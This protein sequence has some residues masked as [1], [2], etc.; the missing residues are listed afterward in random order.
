MSRLIVKNLPKSI[1]DTKVKELFSEK[2]I[3]TD[4]Q[5]K[6][7]KDGKFRRFAFVGYKTEEQ[8][9]LAQSYFNQSCIDTCRISV[10]QCTSLGDSSKP[11][12]WSK[13][14]TDNLHNKDTKTFN[15]KSKKALTNSSEHPNIK[16]GETSEKKEK[17]KAEKKDNEEVRK[18]LEKHKD[19]P[20]FMEFLETHG[21]NKIKAIWRNDIDVSA[22]ATGKSSDNDDDDDDNDDDDDDNDDDD[23]SKNKEDT[24]ESENKEGKE[25]EKKENGKIADK[26]MS[27]LEYMEALKKKQNVK[28]EEKL[29]VQN[30]SNHGSLKLFTVKMSGLGYKHKK[31]DVKLFFRPLKPKSIRIPRKVKGIVYLGF[32]TESQMK[33]ALLKNKSFLDGKQIFVSKYEKKEEFSENSDKIN[34]KWKKQEEALKN[35]ESIAESGRIFLRNLTYTTTEDD[36]RKLFEKYGPLSEVNLPVDKVT[37]KPKGFGI[38]TFLMPEHAIKAYT[39]LD[40][41]VLDGRMLHLLP[42]MAKTSLEDIDLENLTYKQKKELQIKATANS[43]HNWNTLFLEQNA[44]VNTIADTYNITKEKVLEDETK[45]MSAAVKLALGETQIIHDTKAFL[46]ENGVCL[47]AFNQAPQQR[48]RTTILVKNLPAQ[49]KS[50]DIREMFAKH[51]ELGRVVLPP[52]GITALVEFLEPSEARKAFTRLAYT[53]YK[54]LPLY[55][56]WAPDNSFTAPASKRNASKGK[57]TGSSVSEETKEEAATQKS[58]ENVNNSNKKAAA[59]EDDEEPEPDTTL[60]VKNINFSTTTEQ[61][62]SYFAK[63]GRLHYVTIATKKDPKNPSNNLPMGYGFVRYKRK[64]DADRALKT[65]Q[66]TVL[67]GKSLELKRSERILTSDV[68]TAR[69]KSK[70]TEQTG[71][72][73]LVRNVPFQATIQEITE[74]FKAFGQLKAARLPK[75][76]IGVKKHR[77]FAFIEYYTK[78]DAKRAFTSLCQST[79]LYG[80]RLVLEWAQ[81]EEDIEEIRKRTAKRFFQENSAKRFKKSTLDPE[82]VGLEEDA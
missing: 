32:K 11:R 13:Y 51:G 80:R 52:S 6:Y 25:E 44:V 7:T 81:A 70:I 74:L 53:K 67:D 10:E 49:T 3:V 18:A 20:L 36:V 5:L 65:L 19:D 14:A 23:N 4:V 27:D 33:K 57:V 28:C 12:A 78:E 77:G 73:I 46:E 69:K 8:A 62:K 61:L 42:G 75:K 79:H 41:S 17:K 16:S 37:R 40:G 1:T 45:G 48:S 58:R 82:S 50:D 9:H 21:G 24:V 39:E 30:A 29:L 47:D 66:M 72:K 26:I 35:E 55:L 68:K 63:C 15:D 56:E 59:D 31:R 60:F 22:E 54:Y 2:G 71:T 34:I 76:L 64:H 38:V 43:S